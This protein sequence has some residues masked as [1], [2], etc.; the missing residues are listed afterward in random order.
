M[1]SPQRKAKHPATVKFNPAK[2]SNEDDLAHYVFAHL[3]STGTPNGE[4]WDRA[5]LIFKDRGPFTSN[6]RLGIMSHSDNNSN[7][8]RKMPA[9]AKKGSNGHSS[10]FLR[11][12]GQG[13]PTALPEGQRWWAKYAR[14]LIRWRISNGVSRKELAK[15]VGISENTVGRIESAQSAGLTGINMQK[16]EDSIGFSPEQ[17]LELGKPEPK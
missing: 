1:A 13:R 17:G 4:A 11:I 6:G 16:I 9:S 3:V 15:R 10:K 14:G 12:E 2:V 7:G 8:E 5:G